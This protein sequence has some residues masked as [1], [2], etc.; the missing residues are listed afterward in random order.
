M[1]SAQHAPGQPVQL[2][3]EEIAA[4]Q[5][6]RAQ[7]SRGRGKDQPNKDVKDNKEGEGEAEKPE[8]PRRRIL[9]PKGPKQMNTDQY[10]DRLSA[11]RKT[12]DGGKPSA[13]PHRHYHAHKPEKKAENGQK[14]E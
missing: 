8:K 4:R 10:F 5:D 2:T 6:A 3:A 1:H 12:Q 14:S 7:K 9:H 11:E 13:P